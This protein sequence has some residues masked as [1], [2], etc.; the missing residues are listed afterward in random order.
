MSYL[1]FTW[2]SK[3]LPSKRLKMYCYDVITPRRYFIYIIYIITNI[4]YIICY[5]RTGID[6]V[7]FKLVPVTCCALT[8]GMSDWSFT[9]SK[10]KLTMFVLLE[11]PIDLPN[12]VKREHCKTCFW[13]FCFQR[14]PDYQDRTSLSEHFE[15][16][17]KEKTRLLQIMIAVNHLSPSIIHAPL[18][19]CYCQPTLSI[20][21]ILSRSLHTLY[22]LCEYFYLHSDCQSHFAQRDSDQY[23]CYFLSL[24]MTLVHRVISCI[25]LLSFCYLQ[26]IISEFI[27]DSLF[28]L[29]F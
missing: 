16:M 26:N 21:S 27:C 17:S 20:H 15:L 10:L 12:Q 14:T 23:V 5:E 29:S 24:R 6:S 18:H 4:V 25:C 1:L 13:L 7:F 2:Q 11:I 3:S 9:F 22:S 19:L 8:S 28:I